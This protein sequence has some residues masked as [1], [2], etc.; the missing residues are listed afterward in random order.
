LP[1]RQGRVPLALAFAFRDS[2][3]IIVFF[4]P[5]KHIFLDISFCFPSQTVASHLMI[6]PYAS[7]RFFRI[8]HLL[9]ALYVS[10][11][12]ALMPP[13][14]RHNPLRPPL[15][16]RAGP[17]FFGHPGHFY[18]FI[19]ASPACNLQSFERSLSISSPLGAHRLGLASKPLSCFPLLRW[20]TFYT[21]V[22]D[23]KGWPACLKGTSGSPCYLVFLV[24]PPWVPPA[25]PLS[26]L[27]P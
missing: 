19:R 8:F 5:H 13:V 1:K 2:P 6:T 27:A 9:V 26:R 10:S 11:R 3:Y 7:V 24:S 17:L 22:C 15:Y 23:I 4:I 21:G 20:N 14:V 18:S 12:A 25:S 16:A